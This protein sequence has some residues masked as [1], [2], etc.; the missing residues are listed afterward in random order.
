MTT[1]LY[2]VPLVRSVNGQYKLIRLLEQTNQDIMSL[3]NNDRI[4]W[5]GKPSLMSFSLENKREYCKQ[6]GCE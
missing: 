4:L 2:E 6:F 1:K 5:I 3:L